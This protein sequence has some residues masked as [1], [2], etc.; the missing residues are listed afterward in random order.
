METEYEDVDGELSLEERKYLTKAIN[1]AKEGKGIP[2][3]LHQRLRE[4]KKTA[5]LIKSVYFEGL[6]KNV[7]FKEFRMR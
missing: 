3:N 2:S 1:I 4:S 6:E 7:E 5:A